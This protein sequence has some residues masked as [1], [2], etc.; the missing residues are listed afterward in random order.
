MVT[1]PVSYPLSLLLD[2]ALGE[3]MPTV[4]AKDRLIEY[5]KLTR[6]I[7]RLE[8][9]QLNMIA[10]VVYLRDKTVGQVMTKLQ[11]VYMV[12]LDTLLTPRTVRSI[13]KRG[14]SRIPVCVGQRRD[15]IVSILFLKDLV[16]L[17]EPI[18]VKD[19]VQKTNH[20]LEFTDEGEKISKLL[21]YMK[22]GD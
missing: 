20:V 7:N 14:F 11:N 22:K 10:G 21:N 15:R 12:S 18:T 17:S 6:P 9:D 2:Y 16:L 5:I 3:E 1:L 4:Y 8:L 13:F 19:L